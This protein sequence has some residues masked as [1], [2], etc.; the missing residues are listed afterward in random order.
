MKTIIKIIGLAALI[1]LPVSVASQPS[2]FNF[3]PPLEVNGLF[4]DSTYTRDQVQAK[5]GV[6]TYYHSSFSDDGVV[7]FNEGYDYTVGQNNSQFLFLDG[8]LHSFYIATSDFPVFSA[9]SS[10]G[11]RV[12]DNI[13]KVQVLGFGP[14][15]K[16]SDGRYFLG[17]LGDAPLILHVTSAGVITQIW[18]IT[19]V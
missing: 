17:I 9:H 18:Y 2:T 4:V 7:G 16:Q 8:K 12:G 11:I 10:G 5:L 19:P 3:Y 1:M 14:A 15:T 6:P 13:S